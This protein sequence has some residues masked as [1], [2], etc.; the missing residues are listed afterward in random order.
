ML[1]RREHLS[2][3]RKMS[4]ETKKETKKE[5]KEIKEIEEVKSKKV[6]YLIRHAQ[7][8]GNLL[9]TLQGQLE[10]NLTD[11]G[12]RQVQALSS[13]FKEKKTEFKIERVFSSDL[14][15]AFL[16]AEGIAKVLDLKV[17]IEGDFREANYGRWQGV[18]RK[19]IAQEDPLEYQ[20]WLADKRKRP[21]WCESFEE[22]TSRAKKALIRCSQKTTGNFVV[23]SHGGTIHSIVGLSENRKSSYLE[24]MIQNCS[25]SKFLIDFEQDRNELRLELLELNFRPSELLSL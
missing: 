23:L 8:E 1:G 17:E 6:L 4:K 22:T 20:E 3:T 16:T 18:S 24:T 9:K 14:R 5:I 11:K 25:I 2:G 13:Y 15:R 10:A 7:S 19:I 21:T 12:L